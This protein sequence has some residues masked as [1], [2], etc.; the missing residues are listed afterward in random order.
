MNGEENERDFFLDL[1]SMIPDYL[2]VGIISLIYLNILLNVFP[3]IM[4]GEVQQWLWTLRV[5]QV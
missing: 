2:F 5:Q 1:L 3:I 4:I